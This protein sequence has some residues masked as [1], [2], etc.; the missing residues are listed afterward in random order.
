MCGLTGFQRSQHREY[1]RSCRASSVA[2]RNLAEVV[3]ASVLDGHADDVLLVSLHV[4]NELN[5]RHAELTVGRINRMD[6]HLRHATTCDSDRDVV[7][8][9][10]IVSIPLVSTRD[11]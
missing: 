3:V 10:T 6:E 2:H 9:G 1:R 11:T 4:A 7:L 5:V 8:I